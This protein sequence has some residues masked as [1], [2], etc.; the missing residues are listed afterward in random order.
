MSQTDKI[1]ID[2]LQ[3]ERDCWQLAS[4][5]F[6]EGHDFDVIAGITRGGAQISIYMQEVFALLSGKPKA[7]TTI[8]A[9]SYTGVFEADEEVRVENLKSLAA[10]M[11]PDSRLLIVDDIFDR[12][13]TFKAVYEKVI[14]EI[15]CDEAHVMTAAL[16][17]KPENN[18]VDMLPDFYQRTFGSNDWIV[19]PHELEALSREELAA[20]GFVWPEGL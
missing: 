8:H 16:Y 10:R 7:F 2:A 17:Y 13:K 15:D 20:K 19:L 4:N 14:N 11:N 1:F 18:L 5:I 12:G 3:L 9:Q 6:K